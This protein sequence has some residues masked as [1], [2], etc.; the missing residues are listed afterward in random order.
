[1]AGAVEPFDIAFFD[2]VEALARDAAGA[3]DRDLR[4]LLYDRIDWLR[5]T[6]AHV[7]PDARLCAAR[8]RGRSG[9]AWLFLEDHGR[10]A[11]AFAR[12]YTLAVRPVIDGVAGRDALAALARG[13]RGR[14]GHIALQPMTEEDAGVTETAFH[15]AGWRT[16]RAGATGNWVADTQGL[17]FETFWQRRPG[18]LRGTVARRRARMPL[19]PAIHDRFAAEAWQAYE[20]VYAS[21]W[22]PDEGSPA[23]LRALAAQEGAA[24]T[25]RLGIG[26]LAGKPVAAQLWLV[27]GGVATIHKLAYDAGARAASP[28]TQLSAAMFAHVLDRDRPALIDYGTGDDGYKADWMDRRRQLYRLDLYDPASPAGLTALARR[29]AAALV[30]RLR[31]R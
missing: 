18:K 7:L 12:W 26:T 13:L 15:A 3:L 17:D 27:E 19:I 31:G 11:S 16:L 24:G 9:S 25:L 5:L 30:A 10:T 4:P 23:F 14:F 1:M 29:G 28:G 8:A 20:Q 21:S 22:K 2:D 6:A